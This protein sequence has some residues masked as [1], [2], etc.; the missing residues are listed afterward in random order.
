[1]NLNEK[2]SNLLDAGHNRKFIQS[3]LSISN[4]TWNKFKPIGIT[5]P[6][7]QSK[8]IDLSSIKNVAKQLK[9]SGLKKIEIINKLG[10]TNYQYN[11]L[12]LKEIKTSKKQEETE[13]ITSAYFVDK[14][15]F[16]EDKCNWYWV[17]DQND[18]CYMNLNY[19]D[20]N[21]KSEKRVKIHS[22]QRIIN[23]WKETFIL[24]GNNSKEYTSDI[25]CEFFP[26]LKSHNLKVA[27]DCVLKVHF[28]FFTRIL[29]LKKLAHQYRFKKLIKLP[30]VANRNDIIIY[31][32]LYYRI[33]RYSEPARQDKELDH[34]SF[35]PFVKKESEEFTTY[36]IKQWDILISYDAETCRFKTEDEHYNK[37]QHP[38]LLCATLNFNHPGYHEEIRE[39]FF[40]LDLTKKSQVPHNF[41]KW[42]I[43][44]VIFKLPRD[45]QMFIKI[46]LF[47]YNNNKFDNHFIIEELLKYGKC[48]ISERNGKVTEGTV[49]IDNWT[50]V[51][52]D[53][54]KWVPDMTLEQACDDYEI[55]AKKLKLDILTYNYACEN[56]GKIIVKCSE[57]E[58]KTYLKPGT[59]IR[60]KLAL[61]KK[62]YRDG[63]Y[64]IW[65][66]V[67]EYCI[68]DTLSVLELYLK[69]SQVIKEMAI[70]FREQDNVHLYST[71]FS[72]YLSPANFSGHLFKAFAK[73]EGEQKLVIKNFNL[74]RF[75]FESYFGG[76]VDFGFIG[77]YISVNKSL[78]LMDV[79]SEYPLAM[80]GLYPSLTGD[81]DE[82]SY[83]PYLSL[84]WY[85]NKLDLC[86]KERWDAFYNKTLDNFNYFKYL[87][88]W[89]GIFRANCIP[90]E[91]KNHLITFAS[92]PSH[93]KTEQR[94]AYTNEPLL[95]VIINSVQCKNLILSGFKIEILPDEHNI[96]F[97]KVAHV[98]KSYVEK[99]GEMKFK[100]KEKSNKTKAKLVKLFLNSIAGKMAQRPLDNT[101]INQTNFIGGKIIYSSNKFSNENWETSM[102]YLATFITAEANFILFST[103]YRLQLDYIYLDRPL[104]DR[105]GSILYMD[106]DS[107]VFDKELVSNKFIFNISEELGYYDDK[108]HDFYITWK[109]KY[110]K[111]SGVDRII[112]LA[113][114]SYA[115]CENEKIVELKLKGIHKKIM[116]KEFRNY[117]ILKDIAYGI[118]KEV[119]FNSLENARI[120]ITS[121]PDYISIEA[122]NMTQ[123]GFFKHNNSNYHKAPFKELFGAEI[124]K[125]LQREN[126]FNELKSTNNDVININK[127]NLDKIDK[128]FL[129][130]CCSPY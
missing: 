45:L 40:W 81:T 11:K 25:E 96:F 102:H 93:H 12:D 77:E 91:N 63:V 95:N 64:N 28:R 26:L 118:S 79:T 35:K 3:I 58:F 103:M 60:E 7:K 124:K 14:S 1:M 119:V 108:K 61:K 4:D 127:I 38:Y 52:Y 125:T 32:Q 84:E 121:N 129:V 13:I 106:T 62:Y 44:E 54:V 130:F 76:R 98:F 94:I 10:I 97:N 112:C 8:K 115:I 24:D 99:L 55:D 9:E 34:Y 50:I 116:D 104:S 72:E 5:R 65:E 20:E 2:I 36:D 126:N 89:R 22:V 33:L 71:N 29:F 73:K 39:S 110:T 105:T 67:N 80:M 66:Y 41:V 78:C 31:E 70:E 16:R 117:S 18:K 82:I 23:E 128:N 56:A 85:Q 74:G 69:M 123:F 42:I 53:M 109:E 21:L 68:F 27:H 83:G 49:K 59:N 114:K 120:D 43:E 47:G 15:Y 90:P 101:I 122:T 92:I 17:N 87:E 86:Y 111:G 37:L 19:L 6:Y 75:I 48:E 100:A 113:K 107:I 51:L 46:K 57:E 88:T 30:T